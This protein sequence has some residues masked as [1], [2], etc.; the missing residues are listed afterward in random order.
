M[1]KKR[2][3][4]PARPAARK[5]VLRSRTPEKKKPKG[6]PGTPPKIKPRAPLAAKRKV[7]RKT[8]PPQRK[9]TGLV[10]ELSQAVLDAYAAA[11][12][13][14]TQWLGAARRAAGHK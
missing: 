2:K 10:A 8:P 12:L 6:K 9:R 13:E 1:A 11:S 7:K 14:M 3:P 5:K 4:T